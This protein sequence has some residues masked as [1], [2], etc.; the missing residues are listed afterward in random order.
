[1]PVERSTRIRNE[2]LVKNL[3]LIRSGQ[4]GQAVKAFDHYLDETPDEQLRF[5]IAALA[6]VNAN[7]DAIQRHVVEMIEE[8][9]Q[10]MS[11]SREVSSNG[12]PKN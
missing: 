12:F 5:I 11:L 2:N 9:K 3:E 1:M 8:I 6:S 10:V 7:V 4:P